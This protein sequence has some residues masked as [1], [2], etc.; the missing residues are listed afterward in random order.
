M[1]LLYKILIYVINCFVLCWS[2]EKFIFISG[3]WTNFV[4]S[5]VY[6]RH[7]KCRCLYENIVIWLVVS[8][9]SIIVT[10][11]VVMTYSSNY[12]YARCNT[13]YN[14]G[15]SNNNSNYN[16]HNSSV[17]VVK[18]GIRSNF[19][20]WKVHIGHHKYIRVAASN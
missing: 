17:W 2:C 1:Y 9:W 8:H 13:P 7:L 4:K 10:M 20:W 18:N 19:S 3:S 5:F 16:K 15:N 11:V 14:T 6:C 12:A